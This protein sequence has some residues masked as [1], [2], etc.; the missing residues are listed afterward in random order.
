M[1]DET[2]EGEAKAPNGASVRPK[3]GMV[4]KLCSWYVPLRMSCE[5]CEHL[6]HGLLSHSHRL[7]AGL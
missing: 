4:N 2:R 5:V 6:L 7:R 3:A 1:D